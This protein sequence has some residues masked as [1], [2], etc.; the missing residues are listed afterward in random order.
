MVVAPRQLPQSRA[1]GRAVG[2]SSVQF[3]HVTN[4]RQGDDNIIFLAVPVS[5]TC[6][7]PIGTDGIL[8]AHA[9]TAELIR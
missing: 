1:C 2:F 8:I 4:G 9:L 6:G 3:A 7:R 5:G